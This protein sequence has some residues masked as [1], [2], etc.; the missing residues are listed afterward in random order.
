M[1]LTATDNLNSPLVIDKSSK[2][3]YDFILSFLSK[4]GYVRVS[5]VKESGE[6]AVKGDIID[7]FPTEYEN[8]IRINIFDSDIEKLE[9]FNTK[10]QKTIT[11]IKRFIIYPFNEFVFNQNKRKIKADTFLTDLSSFNLNDLIVHVDHG[12]G[13]FKGLKNISVLESQHDCVEI[14]YFNEDKLYIPVENIELLS[15][16]SGNNE[17]V[18][19]DRLGTSHWQFRKA[20]AKKKINEIADELIKTAAERSLKKAPKFKALEPYY[21]N[22]VNEFSYDETEDQINVTSEILNDLNT[23]MP[24]DRLVCGDVGYGKTEVALRGAFNVA[25]G[26]YQVAII[27][28][29]TLLCRQHYENFVNRFKNSPLKIS[30]L[31]RLVS[32]VEANHTIEKINN[33]EIDVVVGTHALLS[34]KIKFKKLGLLIID[35]EQHFGVSQKEKIKNI[36]S[37]IHILSLTATPIPRTL[38]MSLVGLRDLSIISTAPVNRQTIKTEVISFNANKISEAIIAEKNRG[39]QIYYVCPRV[40]ELDEVEDFLKINLPDVTYRI[41]HG[42]MTPKSLENVMVDFYNDEFKILLCTTIVESGLDLSKTNTMIVHN[43]DKFGLSQLYQLRGRIGRANIEAYCYYTISDFNSITETAN[44]RLNLLK[45]LDSR[46]SSFNL[47]SHDLEVRG[48]GNIIGDQQSGHIREIGLEL[49]H[50]LLKEKIIELRSDFHTLDAEWSPQINLG[51][52]VLIPE[53]FIPNLNTRLYF[54]RKLAYLSNIGELKEIKNEMLER[55]GS[56]PDEVF[57][58]F[59]ITELRVLC[60]DLS[61]EKFDLGARGLTIKFRNNK[62][63]KSDE[64]VALISHKKYDLKLRSDQTLVYNFNKTG[65]KQRISKAFHFMKELTTL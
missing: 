24:M 18:E 49:Y 54:Y 61:I 8:P 17:Y 56:I 58:L 59:K 7:I 5:G 14:S 12:I 11:A 33:G 63:E 22:F 57:H 23:G 55:F 47:A 37:D 29:T 32:K 10:T 39:G 3:D 1:N 62:F 64:L 35:E 26:G 15:K 42:Q 16:Y 21:T 38:Q 44:Q 40:S 4:N 50:R 30:Q 25:L 41:A 9:Q 34:D 13:R 31:S 60:K 43:S 36:K 28:P 27:V 48:S 46:G 19:L 45:K 2:F 51:L 65:E 53:Q 20:N 52:N 6:F